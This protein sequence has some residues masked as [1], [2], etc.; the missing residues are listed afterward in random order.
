MKHILYKTTNL[1]NDRYYIG[2][3]STDNLEDGY[4][5]SGKRLKAELVKYGRENFKREILELLPSRT[6]LEK[7]EAEIVTESLRDDPLCLNLKNG[8]EG[9]WILGIGVNIKDQ[10]VDSVSRSRAGRKTWQ[11]R[12]NDPGY[13]E[14][15][16]EKISE[17]SKGLQRFLGKQHSEETKAKMRKSKNV[18]AANSQFGS[19]WVT[20]GV[21]PIKIRKENLNEYLVKGYS[22]GRKRPVS[23]VA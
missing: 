9:G 2:M 15:Y 16:L 1:L 8:G 18:G 3:H 4:L 7:R 22:K 17:S 6:E 10:I 19:C 12:M 21:K 5:G 20:D 14:R 11:A 23:P 13:A